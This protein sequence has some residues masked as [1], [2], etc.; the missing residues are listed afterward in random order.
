MNE[1]VMWLL[2]LLATALLGM[3]GL[4]KRKLTKAKEEKARL[5]DILAKERRQT[6]INQTAEAIKDELAENKAALN[7][8]KGK[9]IQSVSEIPEEKEVQL[10]DEVAELAAAQSARASARVQ[11]MQDSRNKD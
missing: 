11:R 10:S 5:E 8:E 3:F 1:I 6:S 9:V 4:Q 2:G 7:E